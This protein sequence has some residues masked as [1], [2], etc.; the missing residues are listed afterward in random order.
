[1]APAVFADSVMLATLRTVWTSFRIFHAQ[2]EV[3]DKVWNIPAVF[4]ELHGEHQVCKIRSVQFTQPSWKTYQLFCLQLT[5]SCHSPSTWELLMV[6]RC[7]QLAFD[8][9]QWRHKR[10]ASRAAGCSFE[11]SFETHHRKLQNIWVLFIEAISKTFK[12]E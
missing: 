11:H 12:K 6:C 9:E 2:P 5:W 1:M 7:S 3:S 10:R 8:L 4:L